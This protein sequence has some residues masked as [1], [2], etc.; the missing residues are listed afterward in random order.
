MG[1]EEEEPEAEDWQALDEARPTMGW[2]RRA[3]RATEIHTGS[4]EEGTSLGPPPIFT[5]KTRDKDSIQSMGAQSGAQAGPSAQ[6]S[7]PKNRPTTPKQG[8][9]TQTQFDLHPKQPV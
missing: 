9:L 8:G 7:H 2:T 6:A 1:R 5:W 3:A 4:L